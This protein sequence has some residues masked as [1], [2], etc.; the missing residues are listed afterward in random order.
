M[1]ST[2]TPASAQQQPPPTAP[3]R[4]D[5]R[6]VGR[7]LRPDGSP[8]ANHPVVVDAVSSGDLG[9]A[10]FAFFGTFG[11]ACFADAFVDPSTN[12]CIPEGGRV[13][14]HAGRTD[15]QGRYSILLPSA[16]YVG[17]ESNTDFHLRVAMPPAAGQT[18]GPAAEYELEVIDAV[19][20]APDM[21]LWDPRSASRRRAG[22]HASTGNR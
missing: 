22:G 14:R 19:Q 13:T 6:L 15:G 3:Q 16:H 9:T 10:L 21:R 17:Q 20:E 7:L 4:E 11:L 18:S 2:L 1:L 12:V 8:L 5:V